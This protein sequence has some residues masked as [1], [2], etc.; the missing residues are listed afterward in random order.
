MHKV[1]VVILLASAGAASADSKPSVTLGTPTA[2]I[3]SADPKAVTAVMKAA[4][5]SFV[6]CYKET[7][8]NIRGTATAKFKL[9]IDGKVTSVAVTG[10]VSTES[11]PIHNCIAAAIKTLTFASPKDGEVV[12]IT[13]P[14][15]FDPGEESGLGDADIYG[16]IIGNEAGEMNGGF[17]YGR[18]GFGPAGGTGWNMIGTIGTGRYGTIGH[19][20]LG[21]TVSTVTLG[22]PTVKGDLDKAIIRRYIKRNIQ[23]IAFCYEREL[24]TSPKLQGTVMAVF[25][26]GADG[27][28]SASTGSGVDKVGGCVAQVIQRIEFPKPKGASIVDVTYPFMF[29]EPPPANKPAAKKPPAKK[30]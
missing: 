1:A 18:S 25:T 14:L 27:K 13:F 26:I 4:S 23:K 20:N 8:T 10:F 3:G 2:T 17:G 7:H 24:I 9:A 6:A 12:E 30:P 16:G 21:N 5:S 19:G 29:K 22:Q 11:A 15:K 28:V